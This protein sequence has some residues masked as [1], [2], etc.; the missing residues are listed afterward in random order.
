MLFCNRLW[1]NILD[2]N[3]ASPISLF[4]V[5]NT[6]KKAGATS[7]LHLLSFD[8]VLNPF[9][10]RIKKTGF[11]GAKMMLLRVFFFVS[12]PALFHPFR[13]VFPVP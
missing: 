10:F 3:I 11:V 9:Y 1:F 8:H 4:R 13:G 12:T 6:Q 5:A 7:L 2:K